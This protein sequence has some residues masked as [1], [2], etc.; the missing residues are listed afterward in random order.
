MPQQKND[1]KY[2]VVVGGS[3]GGL[4]SLME[5]MA[6]INDNMDIAVLAVLHVVH[7]SIPDVLIRRIQKITSLTCKVATD[8]E[9]IKPNHFYL[10]VPDKHLMIKEG[11][12]LLGEGTAENRWRPSIDVLFRS[13]AAACNGRT[14]GIILS[15]LLQDGTAGM[16]AIKKCGGTT[17]V[18]DPL[19]AEYPDMP[20][21]V[22]DAI[23]VDYCTS[24]T[25]MGAILAEKCSMDIQEKLLP[26]PDPIKKE[27]Q[28]AERVATSIDDVKDLGSKSLYSC[29]GCG[30]GLWEI[31]TSGLRRYR[32]HIG[33][34]YTQNE[35]VMKQNAALESTLWVALRMLE[36]RK[37]LLNKMAKEESDKGWLVMAEKKRLRSQEL[38]KHIERLK[39][40]LFHTKDNITALG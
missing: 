26:I 10:A 6:Q 3:A 34:M 31:V 22:L 13:A 33:H 39:E 14:I 8:G 7:L 12:I 37:N 29:P 11:K 9:L 27:A 19:E 15:G 36:E 4:N 35:L 32:C 30:G 21:S 17:I 23:Q 24:L 1:P 38:E 18:Q 5:L 2:I 16:Q 25:G 40:I 28:I 20:Q